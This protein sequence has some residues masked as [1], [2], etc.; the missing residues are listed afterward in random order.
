MP[1][2]AFP[3][4]AEGMPKITCHLPNI[5]RALDMLDR[6]WSEIELVSMAAEE[7]VI[8]R[9]ATNAIAY[10]CINAQKHLSQAKDC[11]ALGTLSRVDAEGG[12]I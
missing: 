4:A 12:E 6:A 8:E 11:L 7:G 3:A 1:K 5:R 2:H 9:D 10:G